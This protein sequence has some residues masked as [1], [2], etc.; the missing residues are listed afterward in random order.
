MAGS[1]PADPASGATQI[2]LSAR[3][4][5]PVAQ[6]LES[7]ALRDAAKTI[8]AA[9]A[10]RGRR[11]LALCA[12]ASG[13]GVSFLTA[14]LG[15]AI[16]QA[17]VDTLVLDANLRC[18]ALQDLILPPSP[19]VP[20]LLQFLRG[21]CDDPGSI[22]ASAAIPNLSVIHA[23]GAE[24]RPQDLFDTGRFE[25]LLGYCMRAFT[26]VLVDAPPANRCAE[27]RRIASACG[28]AALVARR[29]ET[30]ARDLAVLMT[31][32]RTS[33]VEVIG[34]IFNEG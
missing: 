20:G 5:P 9:H 28:Y 31:E 14:S 17:G 34:T 25:V 12:A 32:L 33:R 26:M 24:A 15:M 1:S 4:A 23:G 6:A 19:H 13:T 3:V 29:D 10:N 21:E 30:A 7:A 11:A 27:T 18:P 16:A 8:I 22:P 2:G